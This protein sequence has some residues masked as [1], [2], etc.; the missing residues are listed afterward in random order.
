MGAI[1]AITSRK[2]R[3]ETKNHG[4]RTTFI[5]NQTVANLSLMALGSSAPEIFLSLID[6]IRKNMHVSELG[7]STIVGSAAFNLL[8]I[9]ALCGVVIPS[10]EVRLIEQYEVFLVTS[11][12]SI[13]AYVWLALIL[14]VI[15]PDVV[16]LWEAVATLLCLPVLIWVSYRSDIGRPV[17]KLCRRPHQ[18][19][20]HTEEDEEMQGGEIQ[21]DCMNST[22]AE[23]S[24]NPDDGMLDVPETSDD[25]WQQH[26]RHGDSVRRTQIRDSDL[27]SETSSSS[28]ED[29]NVKMARKSYASYHNTFSRGYTMRNTCSFSSDTRQSRRNSISGSTS[30][31]SITTVQFAVDYQC[32]SAPVATKSVRIIRTGSA[33]VG[34]KIQYV[35]HLTKG[36]PAADA[37][38]RAIPLQETGAF[39][40]EDLP[41]DYQA[42][43]RDEIERGFV[44]LDVCSLGCDIEVKRPVGNNN[45]DPGFLVTLLQVEVVSKMG[46]QD[47]ETGSHA[48]LGRLT[49]SYVVVSPEASSG[50]IG[51]ASEEERVFGKAESQILNMIIIRYGGC[52]G[53]VSA[54]YSV[55]QL[56][57]VSGIDFVENSGYLS[58]EDGETET[59]IE[60][61]LP[62]KS[63]HRAECSFLFVIEPAEKGFGEPCAFDPNSDGGEDS[64]ICTITVLPL[65]DQ[66]PSTWMT[67]DEKFNLALYYAGCLDWKEEF[68]AIFYCNGSKE[69]QADATV[70]DWIFFALSFPWRL[71][72]AAIPPATFGRGWSCFNISLIYI[73]LLTALVADLAELFGCV[74][75]VP[76]IINAITF[77]ALGTSLPDLC[78]SK[79]A[80]T[81]DP[82][83]DSSIVNVTGSNSVNVFLGLGMP[84]TIAAIYWMVTP[85]TAAW[86]SKYQEAAAMYEGCVFVVRAG[87]MGFSVV[88][89]CICSAAALSLKIVRRKYIGCE[90][91]GP[92]DVKTSFSFTFVAYWVGYVT[93]VSWRAMRWDEAGA[94]EMALVM[95]GIGFGEIAVSL[96]LL[97]VLASRQWH[98][99]DVTND[100]VDDIGK[101]LGE[102]EPRNPMERSSI[103]ESV[104]QE[105]S[106]DLFSEPRL[107]PPR[108]TL[109]GSGVQAGRRLP[110]GKQETI[111]PPR[112]G[113]PSASQKQIRDDFATAAA[114]GATES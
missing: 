53:Q 60:I 26:Q 101:I 72:F 30:G 86:E 85:R 21:C 64:A 51:F 110:S 106:A 82:T 112:Y 24:E 98:P 44:N 54:G 65:D 27:K 33:T 99:P 37:Q 17:W 113:R 34:L 32:M 48:V 83:A 70:A 36:V 111:A 19:P 46:N 67:L 90:L 11:A 78:A 73:G 15:S 22:R 8:I 80:A 40:G 68:I 3:I 94:L 25:A 62:P 41:V 105:M 97:W 81:D 5:W 2:K 13:F 69:A 20:G 89:F 38:I 55:Q 104:L 18:E 92:F 16:E 14:V 77:V 96:G 71:S 107:T 47:D 87:N 49:S 42:F 50:F 109:L 39:N 95:G 93:I 52:V 84:W 66:K 79:V 100:D 45:S 88:V 103:E 1:E 91:G 74:C 76:N 75:G 7:A 59:C 4:K 58:F 31:D 63:P 108:P 43:A 29:I 28:K 56:T 6:L 23:L 61:H 10:G 102:E 35:V 9:V 57:G 114:A 12:F